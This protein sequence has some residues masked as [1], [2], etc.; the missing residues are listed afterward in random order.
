MNANTRKVLLDLN[1]KFYIDTADDFSKS[2][3]IPWAGWQR[4]IEYFKDLPFDPKALIDLGCGNGRFIE[5]VRKYYPDLSA[6]GVD[7]SKQLL[8]IAE[9]K[10]PNT[11]FLQKDLTLDLKLNKKFD[12][13]A[14]IAVLHHIPGSEKRAEL[15]GRSAQLLSPNGKMLA[16]FWNLD[17][18]PELLD[19]RLPFSTVGIK[20]EE[21]ETGDYLLTWNNDKNLVRYVHSFTQ[22]EAEQLMTQAELKIE[23]TYKADGRSGDSN[24]YIIA[25]V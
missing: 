12:F 21:C 13:V 14:L 23:K 15:I 5:Y 6:T 4:V 1:K 10:N 11:E 2:R 9:E 3:G 20:E 24:Y 17:T 22:E 25:S 8:K 18:Q 19:R 16:T 7:S